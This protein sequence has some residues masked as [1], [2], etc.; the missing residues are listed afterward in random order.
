MIDRNGGWPKI[1]T[2]GEEASRSAWLLVQHA[3]ADPPF[4]LRALRLMEPLVA[5][6]EVSKSDYAYLYDRVMLKIAG[7]QRYGTQ[8][9]CRG[10]NRVPQPLESESSVDS[11]RAEVGLPPIS[12]YLALMQNQFG[13]CP[14]ER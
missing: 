1:S 13:N 9:T 4:Q 3:D 8:A 5:S 11:R 2:V 7:K 14:P 12:E 6:G 10:G